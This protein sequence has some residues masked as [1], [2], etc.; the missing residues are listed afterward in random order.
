MRSNFMVYPR[1]RGGEKSL[2]R[3]LA[4]KTCGSQCIRCSPLSKNIAVRSS[5]PSQAGSTHRATTLIKTSDFPVPLGPYSSTTSPRPTPF[6]LPGTLPDTLGHK[7]ED[8][9]RDL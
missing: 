7:Y 2:S 1:E 9:D 4:R 8:D 6:S 5:P 3:N